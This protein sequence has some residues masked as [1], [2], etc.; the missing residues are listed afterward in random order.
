MTKEEEKKEKEKKRTGEK[1][2]RGIIRKIEIIIRNW[3]GRK[4]RI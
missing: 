1:G 3:R 2:I 4:R